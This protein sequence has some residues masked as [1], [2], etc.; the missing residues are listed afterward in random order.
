MKVSDNH[1]PVAHTCFNILDLPEVYSSVDKLKQQ[2]I[3]AIE[4]T[5]GFTLA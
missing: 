3:I 5:L 1:F 4:N 2:L